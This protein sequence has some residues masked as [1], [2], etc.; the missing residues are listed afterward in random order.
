VVA[1]PVK[2]SVVWS[3][4]ALASIAYLLAMVIGGALPELRTRVKFE[5]QGVMTLAPE[6][7]DRI[8]I[9]RGT[10]HVALARTS[11]GGWSRQGGE[12]LS[13]PVAAQVSLAVQYM[14][15]AGPVR[16]MTAEEIRGI[17]PAE[18]GLAPPEL[19]VTLFSG[20]ERMLRARFGA[21]N[22]EDLLQYMTLDGRD[23]MYLMSRFVGQQWDAS[24]EA[25]EPR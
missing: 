20:P 21:R 24:I 3:L 17:A 8:E 16:V 9:E 1:P 23:D 6:R 5:A 7:V 18:F 10:R 2:R 12:P 4:A 15:T 19:S 11:S 25:V 13:V 22:A 14:R